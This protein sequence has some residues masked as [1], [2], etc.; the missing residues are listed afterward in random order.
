[1]ENLYLY[2]WKNYISNTN[3]SELESSKN[4]IGRVISIKGNIHEVVTET[5]VLKAELPGKLLYACE[6][7]EQPKVGDWVKYLDYGDN[8]FIEDVLPRF[9]QLYRKTAGKEIEKQVMV[10]NVD[11]AVVVQGVD[12][13]FNINRMERYVLQ[14]LTCKITP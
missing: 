9:N 13:D 6:K 5:G 12:N 8:S 3:H 2:G 14:I 10:T 1:M 7:W 11:K 4:K